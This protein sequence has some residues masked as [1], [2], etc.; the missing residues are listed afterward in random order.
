MAEQIEGSES[1]ERF[2]RIIH[3]EGLE[4]F[5]EENLTRLSKAFSDSIVD[6]IP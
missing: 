4:G 6:E 2:H 1:S 5:R 3:P